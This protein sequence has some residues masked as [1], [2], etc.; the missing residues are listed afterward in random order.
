MHFHVTAVMCFLCAQKRKAGFGIENYKAHVHYTRLWS[1]RQYLQL[2]IISRSFLQFIYFLWRNKHFPTPYLRLQQTGLDKKN[3]WEPQLCLTSSLHTMHSDH[4]AHNP[5]SEANTCSSDK[6]ML[7]FCVLPPWRWKQYV[8]P[9]R[10]Y[11]HICSQGVIT[12]RNQHLHRLKSNTLSWEILR[13][14]ST[15]STTRPHRP[16]NHRQALSTPVIFWRSRVQLLA[17]N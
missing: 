11:L 5:L 1:R 10:W 3:R 2:N 14:P 17:Q 16:D 7:I 12:Q 8:L 13:R 4:L 6:S 15:T 9:K